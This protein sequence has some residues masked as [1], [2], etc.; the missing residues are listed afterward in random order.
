MEK[1]SNPTLQVDTYIDEIKAA[2]DLA[3]WNAIADDQKVQ[4]A[5]TAV[6]TI[7]YSHSNEFYHA[8]SYLLNCISRAYLEATTKPKRKAKAK[9]KAKAKSQPAETTTADHA[10][11]T[12]IVFSS[13][14]EYV[15]GDY[16]GAH[17]KP[18]L[19]AFTSDRAMLSTALRA[20]AGAPFSKLV[21]FP[22]NI[23]F[24]EWKGES[25]ALGQLLWYL[26]ALKRCRPDLHTV[27]G[28]FIDA[29]KRLML[30]SVNPCG[31]WSS[32]PVNMGFQ[33]LA[34]AEPQS[35]TSG[36]KGKGKAKKA[37]VKMTIP[38]TDT[39]IAYVVLLYKTHVARDARFSLAERP[40]DTTLWNFQFPGFQPVTVL[41]FHATHCPGRMTWAS[42]VLKPDTSLSSSSSSS[43]SPSSVSPSAASS[44]SSSRSPSPSP[45][46]SLST[47]PTA[48]PRVKG[49]LKTSWQDCS[50]RF[51]ETLLLQRAHNDAWLPG[52]VRHWHETSTIDPS[53]ITLHLP[54]SPHTA[55]V[56]ELVHLAS[57]GQPLSQC[58]SA[59]H[60]LKVIYDATETHLRL[61]GKGILHGD[62]SWFN[63]LCNPWHDKKTLGVRPV[64]EGV[65]CIDYILTAD[66]EKS[67]PRA[68]ILDLDHAAISKVLYGKNY[69]GRQEKTGTPMFVAVELSSKSPIVSGRHS[70]TAIIDRLATLDRPEY[71]E[72]RK[73]AFPDDDFQFM[74]RF[75]H[76][77]SE[78]DKRI[79]A[80]I[81]AFTDPDTPHR[82]H[83]DVESLY[84]VLLW[85]FSRACPLG[86]SPHGGPNDPF[87]LFAEVML[88]HRLGEET[89]RSEKLTGN[90]PVPDLFDPELRPHIY[91]ALKDLAT[92][93][94]VPWHLYVNDVHPSHAH[95]ALRRILLPLIHKIQ[96]GKEGF[97]NVLFDTTQPR[98]ILKWSAAVNRKSPTGPGTPSI[99]KT[100]SSSRLISSN[101]RCP[102][103]AAMP[104]PPVQNVPEVFVPPQFDEDDGE[105]WDAYP[106]DYYKHS[107]ASAG[108]KRPS[109][110]TESEPEQKRA[111]LDLKV[112][113]HAR[114]PDAL[115][116]MFY[117]DR[118][119][120]FGN[121][122]H[123]E[124]DA[125]EALR[126]ALAGR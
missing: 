53:P 17:V 11:T 76:V 25:G 120:W 109:D 45:S 74:A 78:E 86:K 42:F 73:R 16:L 62:M 84:W 7:G 58:R 10:Q 124:G 106:D 112:K 100:L 5:L 12:A 117:A 35:L 32:K 119:L 33:E 20:S 97:K 92:Y 75:R 24:G 126:A 44:P 95:V 121:G 72:L 93:L 29:G 56:Q 49:F 68:L 110:D 1:E 67:R 105:A 108:E 111:K 21:N 51:F 104:L 118:R 99:L 39:W 115:I 107:A 15:P 30:V 87:S 122:F 31:S 3:V 90:G 101:S 4:N 22:L 34:C 70:L 94:A 23:S 98:T 114:D 69:K 61:L 85:A 96:N 82:P 116:Q 88:D 26:A 65:P 50:S 59:L 38:S 123:N 48:S 83:H 14:R 113:R 71:A 27:H 40:D 37:E 102:A 2:A 64:A 81:E 19:H 54:P 91:P 46:E 103:P 55:R 66:K 57:V 8:A 18:D 79:A 80:N 89:I 60:L 47:S 63:I 125:R 36:R 9:A 77:A 13:A 52:L 28:L 41:P 6:A 43:S